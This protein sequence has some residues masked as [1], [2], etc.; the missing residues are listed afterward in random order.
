MSRRYDSEEA[1]RRI[2]SSCVRLFI[3]RG[4]RETKLADVIAEADVSS[5]TFHN[6]FRTKDGVLMELVEFMFENQ[7]GMAR[8]VAG[9]ELPPACRA[10]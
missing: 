6:I 9:A 7:F 2:L 4:Y 10:L 8:S 5:S 3:L 1:K